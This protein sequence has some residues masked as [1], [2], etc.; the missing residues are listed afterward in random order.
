MIEDFT[1]LRLF[2][3][4]DNLSQ[5]ELGL[6]ADNTEVLNFDTDDVVCTEDTD[7]N[8]MYFIY[9]GEKLSD[10]KLVIEGKLR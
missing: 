10:A 4:F 8:S 5:D 9:Q 1:K 7:S 2:N 6:I 3:L